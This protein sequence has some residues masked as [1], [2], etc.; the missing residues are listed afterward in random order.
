[1]G[2]H[3]VK[4]KTPAPAP[5]P[6]KA[7]DPIPPGADALL[8]RQQVCA[9]LGGISLRTLDKMLALGEYPPP[10][11]RVAGGKR[12]HVA[13]HNEALAKMRRQA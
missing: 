12:W 9:A 5:P 10:D 13:T 2:D 1:M 8:N 3:E 4:T 6:R 11:A 7:A